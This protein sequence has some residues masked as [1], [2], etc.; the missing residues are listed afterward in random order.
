MKIVEDEDRFCESV[1]PWS[2]SDLPV[3]LSFNKV[4]EW[5]NEKVGCGEYIL[6]SPDS[7]PHPKSRWQYFYRYSLTGDKAYGDN[8]HILEKLWFRTENE[9]LL[10]VIGFAG[11]IN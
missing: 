9:A 7:Y 3:M 4:S 2:V 8:D 10:F 11:E 1:M 6:Y 5:L